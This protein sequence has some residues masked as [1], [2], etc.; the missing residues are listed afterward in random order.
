MREGMRKETAR[1][2]EEMTEICELA[3][4][5]DEREWSH[6]PSVDQQRVRIITCLLLINDLIISI[7]L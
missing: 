6:M 1:K 3:V 5:D 2:Y 7:H 4:K